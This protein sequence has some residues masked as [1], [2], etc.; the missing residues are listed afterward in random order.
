MC[1]EVEAGNFAT[2]VYSVFPNVGK[3][4]LEMAEVL[5]ENSVIIA[6]DL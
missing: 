6:N 5:W 2:L 4:I 3:S 1:C